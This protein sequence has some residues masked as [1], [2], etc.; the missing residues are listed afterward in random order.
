MRKLYFVYAFAI[1]VIVREFLWT[2]KHLASFSPRGLALNITKSC[3]EQCHSMFLSVLEYSSQQHVNNKNARMDHQDEWKECRCDDLFCNQTTTTT[4]ITTPSSSSHDTATSPFLSHCNW[5]HTAIDALVY[6]VENNKNQN[7]CS[8]EEMEKF[9]PPHEWDHYNFGDFFKR[10]Q[11][12]G[13]D[14]WHQNYKKQG[15]IM[16][17]FY[18]YAT[19]NFDMSDPAI[20]KAQKY[21]ILTHV[22]QERLS[23]QNNNDNHHDNSP[24]PNTLL[25]HLRLGDVIDS[26]AADSVSEL[27]QEQRYYWRRKSKTQKGCCSNPWE[28][29]EYPP[30]KEPYN[31][32]VRPLSYYTT[33]LLQQ[34][35]THVV[36][37]GSAHRGDFILPEPFRTCHKSC[38]YARAL[39]GYIQTIWPHVTVT[40]RLGQSPDADMVFAAQADG[41][42][43]SGGGYSK[44][45]GVL[46]R[47]VVRKEKPQTLSLS[48]A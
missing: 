11:A 26:A 41:F 31:A 10:V 47:N 25:I 43:E 19:Q 16:E 35:Y 14:K 17:E 6:W 24:P 7:L 18:N 15:S 40:L 2:Q 46:Q 20:Y 42:L 44:L 13:G 9:Y 34:N 38:L 48:G 36:L 8:V 29:P 12:W 45:L 28:H 21:K 27:L 5:S 30:F 39:Q 33:Q 3:P 23:H 4:P 1:V 37:M 22:V 32:Y